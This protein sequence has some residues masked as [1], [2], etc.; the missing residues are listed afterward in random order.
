M[1]IADDQASKEAK[2]RKANELA[3]NQGRA[4]TNLTGA[5]GSGTKLGS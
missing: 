4:S 1:P 5:G 2:S 3:M